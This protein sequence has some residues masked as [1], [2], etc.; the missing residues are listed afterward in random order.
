[1]GLAAAHPA[2]L[3]RCWHC[4][5]CVCQHVKIYD[6][7]YKR[8]LTRIF[9]SAFCS[10]GG[11]VCHYLP[12]NGISGN[13]IPRDRKKTLN[14]WGNLDEACLSGYGVG[15]G[16]GSGTQDLRPTPPQN[17]YESPMKLFA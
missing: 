2:G 10:K 14:R 1:M 6:L 17:L 8:N 11:I 9:T 13:G 12:A 16:A 7:N 15:F 4:W 3:W 5:S